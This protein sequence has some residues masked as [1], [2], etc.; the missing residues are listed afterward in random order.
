[1]HVTGPIGFGADSS[2][3]FAGID[4]KLLYAAM[5]VVIIIL[6][7]TY[8]SPILWLI[9]LISAG[10][11]LF[12][13]QAVIYYLADSDSLTVNAQSSAILTVI[14]FGAGTDYALLLVA[15]YRE[16]LRRHQDRHEAMAFAL[17][18]AGPAIFASGST[19]IAG[20][21][22]LLVA[23]MSST[24]GLGPVAAIGIGVALLVMLTLLPA[25]LV[26]FGRWIF[27]PVRPTYGSADHTRDGFWARTGNRISRA[28]RRTWV[29][30]SVVL[31]IA[32]LGVLQLNATG[33]ANKDAFYTTPESVVGEQVLARHFPAGSGSPRP[34]PGQHGTGRDRA[35]QARD[36][37]GRQLGGGPDRPQRAVAHR[38]DA[39]RRSRL[40]RGHEVGRPDPGCDRRGAGCRRDRRR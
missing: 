1:M 40:R 31:A 7:I 5:A 29:V 37:P 17:H 23:T 38:D 33:L 36:R 15:R 39:E 22:C 2:E 16:E 4:G 34:R 28:P 24:S 27:W 25:L 9:P 30:T 10:T 14:V 19:V 6:L 26:V 11:A 35:G 20:M 21:L 3:A 12:I 32:T 18:R 13:S 8:R